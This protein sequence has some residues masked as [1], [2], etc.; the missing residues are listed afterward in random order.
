MNN[1][2]YKPITNKRMTDI[3]I[4]KWQKWCLKYGLTYQE[5]KLACLVVIKNTQNHRS[6]AIGT[7]CRDGIRANF[8][9]N[10][11]L[12][13]LGLKEN[14]YIDHHDYMNNVKEFYKLVDELEG[15]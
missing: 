5:N 12:L 15:V 9:Y 1:E 13:L 10:N 7:Q 11:F 3:S 6:V 2:Q 14:K 8:D 4:E